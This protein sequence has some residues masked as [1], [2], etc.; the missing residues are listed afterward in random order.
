VNVK[1]DRVA[2][3]AIPAREYA[4]VFGTAVVV[5]FLL[6][7]VVRLIAVRLGVVTPIRDRDVHSLPI[8][9]MGGV[10]VYA[11]F[12]AAVLMAV[13][14]PALGGAFISSSEVLGV[15]AAGGLICLVGVLDDRFDLDAIA[16][17][18]GQ[19][20]AAGILV[21]F[22]V[23]WQ[24]IWLPSDGP[25][26]GSI[27]TLDQTQGIVLTVLLT[28]VLT[29][30]MNFIDGLDGLLA[31]VAAISAFAIFIFSAR[32]LSLSGDVGSASQSPLIAAA[33]VGACIG[34]L[35][36]NFSPARIFMGDSGAMFIGLAMAGATVSASGK[37]D[38]S[39][40]G[41]RSNIALLAPLIV[42]LAVVFIPV[43]D[44]LL[45]VIRRTKEGRHPFS[46]DK[47]H[48][49][50]RM[51]AIGHT[52]R[53]A[54]L[55]FYYWAFVLAAGAVSLVFV[56]WEVAIMPFAVLVAVGLGFSLWPRVRAR[57]LTRRRSGAAPAA[58]P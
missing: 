38:T 27:V 39:T 33:L 11:G 6:T 48:L 14:L 56:S 44:F 2:D 40:F 42:A 19:I 15:L 49:H 41:P 45:A 58:V 47:Q 51:L 13:Q 21:I 35:P 43:L 34:F 53:Q 46:A 36:H 1:P 37:I 55:I 29:N 24:L 16:K 57:R 54:V 12:A 32:Q 23:Q 30:A 4:L 17:L 22:G 9:R 50:H 26:G 52:H 3:F 28:V 7:G 18:A 31:G 8:P 10:A 25:T 5:T 20:L